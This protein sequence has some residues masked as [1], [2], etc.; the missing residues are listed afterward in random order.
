MGPVNTQKNIDKLE[1][2]QRQ[3]ARFVMNRYHNTSSVSQLIETLG[4][5]SLEQ[6]RQI[7]RLSM[8]FK[9]HTNLAH[10]LIIRSKLAPLPSRQRCS[11]SR[12][13]QLIACRTQY[14]GASFLPLTVKD[15]NGLEENTMAALTL[16]TFV[17]RVSK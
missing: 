1:S 10:C 16:D 5:Q 11:H 8:L 3:A 9:I 2:I 15:W 13:F 7:S 6:R 17:S 4:W 14:T 12:Q